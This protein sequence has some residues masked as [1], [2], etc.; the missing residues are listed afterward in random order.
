[1]SGGLDG[2]PLILYSVGMTKTA[3]TTITAKCDTCK[4]PAKTYKKVK[5][6]ST[7]RCGAVA[8]R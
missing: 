5:V 6:C 7:L 3:T 8:P 2:P 1:M 4:G